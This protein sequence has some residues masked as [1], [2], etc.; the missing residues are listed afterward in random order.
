M[1]DV[2]NVIQKRKSVRNYSAD[3]VSSDDLKAIVNAAIWAPNAMNKQAWHFTCV[4]DPAL[5]GKM[6]EAC[7]KGLEGSGVPFLQ[8]RAKSPDF[9]AFFHAPAV[10]VVSIAED[11]FTAFDAGSASATLCLAAKA[12]GYGT[13]ITASTEFMLAGDPA[14]REELEFPENYK[15]ICAI[16]LGRE[17]DGP[18]DHVR[19]RK[20]D[21]ISYK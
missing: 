5:I 14:L 9:H 4:T 18:D 2:L 3:P 12:L 20:E 1:N 19:E 10:I 8:E 6:S 21:V 13:C 17:I 16:T 15:F 11:K 7:R